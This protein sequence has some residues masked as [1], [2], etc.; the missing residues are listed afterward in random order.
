[1]RSTDQSINPPSPTLPHRT[2]PNAFSPDFLAKVRDQEETLTATEAASAGPW[3]VES[4]LGRPGLLAV[5]RE[6]ES[7]DR[8]DVPE[9]L[10]RHEET[11]RLFA[12]I[13]PPAGREPL[14]HLAEIPEER[15]GFPLTAV[16]GEQGACTVGWLRRSEPD[17]VAALHLAEAMVRSPAALAVLLQVAGSGAI[18]QVGR[19]LAETAGK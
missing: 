7:V 13:L 17:L 15:D 2:A 10:F 3:K 18:E 4:V 14:F 9:A 16:Y 8:G 6:W 1:M 5:V 19:I 11:A 12:A